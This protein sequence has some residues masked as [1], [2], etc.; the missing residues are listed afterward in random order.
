M[1][2]ERRRLSMAYDVAKGMNYL[3]KGNPPIVHRDL[4]SPNLLVDK[5][6]T[7][8]V[9]AAV[10]FKCKRLEIP[11]DLN[12]Q[13][14]KIIEACWANEPWKRPSFANIMDMLRPLIKPATTPQQGRTD[15]QLLT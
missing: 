5:K 8:K 10:G 4:K 13:V 14:A 9:V 3:H 15:M 11:R 7:V 1:L 12:P 6:Y 2:D